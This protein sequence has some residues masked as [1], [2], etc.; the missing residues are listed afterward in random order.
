MKKENLKLVLAFLAFVVAAA[1]AILSLF[2]PPEGVIDTSA[3]WGIAQFL[4]MCCTILGIDAELEKFLAR[5]QN[6]KNK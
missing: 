4:V 3:L 2:I 5:M 6:E 1:I